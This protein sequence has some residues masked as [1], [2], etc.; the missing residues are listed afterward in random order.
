M[1]A[2]APTTPIRLL[3]VDDEPE[4]R[5]LLAEYFTRQG[6]GVQTAGSADEARR[7]VA[8]ARP[9]LALLDVTMP[10]EN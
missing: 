4:M 1:Y 5:G 7:L 2:P 8:E 3:V 10:G 6:F 9:D